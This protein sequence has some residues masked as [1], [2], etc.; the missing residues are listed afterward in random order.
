MPILYVVA[1][2]VVVS[3]LGLA[4]GVM[5]LSSPRLFARISRVDWMADIVD[6]FARRSPWEIRLVGFI[7]A[8]VSAW[9]LVVLIQ[10]LLR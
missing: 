7:V 5:M 10:V 4:W 9:I 6:D 1:I 8:A 2:G 3:V